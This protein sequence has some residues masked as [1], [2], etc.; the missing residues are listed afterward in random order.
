MRKGDPMVGIWMD[1]SAGGVWGARAAVV[2]VR[3]LVYVCVC[4]CVCVC[5]CVCVRVCVLCVCVVCVCVCGC[6]CGCG[7]GCECVSACGCARVHACV[8]AYS[9]CV[10]VL[11]CF[12]CVRTCHACMLFTTY[13]L[14]NLLHNSILLLRTFLAPHMSTF[15]FLASRCCV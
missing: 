6:G 12:V 11:V 2:F 7:C 13:L 4:L 9:T 14:H 10:Y 1:E 3:A 5:V 8:L 15:C